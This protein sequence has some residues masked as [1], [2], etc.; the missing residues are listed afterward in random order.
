MKTF[1]R[2]TFGNENEYKALFYI[3]NFYIDNPKSR[4][5]IGKFF[6]E[7]YNKSAEVEAVQSLEF[8][9]E[10]CKI[11]SDRLNEM[12]DM[13]IFYDYDLATRLRNM[14]YAIF[15]KISNKATLQAIEN[16]KE[17]IKKQ[18][19]ESKFS[20]LL[21]KLKEYE[22]KDYHSILINKPSVST[23]K[24]SKEVLQKIYHNDPTY[25]FSLTLGHMSDGSITL[26]WKKGND[27]LH[28]HIFHE[29]VIYKSNTN[30][31]LKSIFSE[32]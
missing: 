31:R 7:L 2:G 29:G 10:L 6:R 22:I 13:F 8:K 9:I 32:M 16:R 17:F 28:I 27:F 5:E 23:I 20:V 15:S 19:C 3:N 4:K 24:L 1:D 21:T 18:K 25:M 26:T 11:Y 12:A 14:V 30:E